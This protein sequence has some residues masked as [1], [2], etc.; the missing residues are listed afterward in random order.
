MGSKNQN[1]SPCEEE[2]RGVKL[3][4][5]DQFEAHFVAVLGACEKRR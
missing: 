1:F 3:G 2:N 4:M 5:L